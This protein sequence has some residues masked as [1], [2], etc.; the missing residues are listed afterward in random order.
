[1]LAKVRGILWSEK[2][3][4]TRV[5]KVCSLLAWHQLTFMMIIMNS[6]GKCLCNP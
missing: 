4:G 6:C 2:G 3:C 1:M 5:G